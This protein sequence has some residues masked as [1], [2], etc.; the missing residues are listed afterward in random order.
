MPGQRDAFG[1]HAF[2]QVAVA[3]DHECA[4]VDDRV[5][6]TVVARREL[7]F[8]DRPC[9]R[10]GQALASG[11]VVT[12]KPGGCPRAGWPGAL[13]APSPKG[14]DVVERERIARQMEQAVESNMEPWPADSTK[15][16][17]SAQS[18]LRD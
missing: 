1:R 9:P 10:I 2:H 6:R 4:M 11:P 3:D 18:G 8:A 13:A 17:R 15:R 14:L 16:S 12:S 7:G 5:P